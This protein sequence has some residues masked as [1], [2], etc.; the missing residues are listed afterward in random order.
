MHECSE[1]ELSLFTTCLSLYRLQLHLPEGLGIGAL[2][3]TMQT[4]IEAEVN[5]RSTPEA[6]VMQQE[7]DMALTGRPGPQE[8]HLTLKK[9][10]KVET[11]GE[12]EADMIH[13]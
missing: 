7:T 6:L 1:F 8:S 10:G 9:E 11:I 2:V 4:R 12:K 3:L 5:I 13:L